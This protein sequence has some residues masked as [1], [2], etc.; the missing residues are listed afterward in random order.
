M[1]LK[2]PRPIKCS[3]SLSEAKPTHTQTHTQGER[4]LPKSQSSCFFFPLWGIDLSVH[5]SLCFCLSPFGLLH[6]RQS[7][8]FLEI[9]NGRALYIRQTGELGLHSSTLRSDW[10]KSSQR[11]CCVPWW[12][13]LVSEP[14]RCEQPIQ[15]QKAS[16]DPPMA[17]FSPFPFLRPSISCTNIGLRSHFHTHCRYFSAFSTSDCRPPNNRSFYVDFWPSGPR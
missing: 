17:S 2:A 10:M 5:V 9:S 8:R 14:T 16:F 1:R 13:R 6:G 7:K 4:C 11:G 15:L 3:A 12:A